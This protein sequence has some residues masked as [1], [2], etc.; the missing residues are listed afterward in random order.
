MAF[1]YLVRRE[2]Y[3][4]G[5]IFCKKKKSVEVESPKGIILQSSMSHVVFGGILGVLVI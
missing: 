4:A 3:L 5:G 2:A 1:L